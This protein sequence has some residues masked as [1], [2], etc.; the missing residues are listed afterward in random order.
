MLSTTSKITL[1][2]E[3]KGPVLIKQF[4]RSENYSFIV[5]GSISRVS[6]PVPRNC[7]E[8]KYRQNY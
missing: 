7:N 4:V 3:Q 5:R 2:Y 6:I 8:Q 1:N